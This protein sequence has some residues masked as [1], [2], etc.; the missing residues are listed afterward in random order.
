M[1]P[2]GVLG[3]ISNR[4]KYSTWQIW[5]IVN[6]KISRIKVILIILAVVVF[7]SIVTLGYFIWDFYRPV[8]YVT[9][10][11]VYHERFSSD[12][13]SIFAHARQGYA[14]IHHSPPGTRLIIDIET[15][16][17]LMRFQ[18]NRSTRYNLV[19]L[20]GDGTVG[21]QR[22]SRAGFFD[23][24]QIS[25]NALL[26][27]ESGRE[28]IPFDSGYSRIEQVSNGLAIVREPDRPD[29]FRARYY[30]VIEIESG[31]VI[32]P[33]EYEEISFLSENL[34]SAM[35]RVEDED[36]RT[37]RRWGVIDASTGATVWPFQYEG[38]FRISPN[39]TR[40]ENLVLFEYGRDNAKLIDINTGETLIPTYSEFIPRLSA[41]YGMA[42]VSC[43]EQAEEG[44]QQGWRRNNGLIEIESGNVIIPFGEFYRIIILS[45]N[46]VMVQA[47]SHRLVDADFGV[48]NI[49]S[50]EEVVP[51]GT[52]FL[53]VVF[54]VRFY[55]DML[56]KIR[57]NG[58]NVIIDLTTGEE[59]IQ[60]GTYNIHRLLP[61]G[62]VVV[63]D[64]N[65]W[66]IEK[67]QR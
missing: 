2:F 5:E 34:I 12:C 62:F 16:R 21:L 55:D 13:D 53:G 64:D 38:I 58:E 61:D 45:E 31:R 14:V 10:R 43:R 50:G 6:M 18:N 65:Y 15:G 24:T 19:G 8:D 42:E 29:G 63:S 35:I 67:I 20:R 57:L 17:E 36:D 54:A 30:G 47:G 37:R 25:E 52:Q 51:I 46:F 49:H 28:L 40:G 9:R 66:W 39:E 1:Q 27:I 33:F 41:G 7:A 44:L 48:I 59:I 23:S 4:E 56:L 60:F 3:G 32:V 11:P 26:E 22:I